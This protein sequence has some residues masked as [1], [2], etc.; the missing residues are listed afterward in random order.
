MNLDACLDKLRKRLLES[1]GEDNAMSFIHNII[2]ALEEDSIKVR[3]EKFLL[4]VCLQFNIERPT[5]LNSKS[6]GDRII[7]ICCYYL[8]HTKLSLNFLSIAKIFEKEKKIY[9]SEGIEEAASLREIKKHEF[10]LVFNKVEKEFN[11]HCE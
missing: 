6:P 7:R 5:L 10:M 4:Q 9:I 2:D 8:L 1:V 3:I 11:N